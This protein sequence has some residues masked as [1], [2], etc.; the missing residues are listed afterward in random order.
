MKTKN[1]NR[2]EIEAI[3]SSPLYQ[4]L[5]NDITKARKILQLYISAGDNYYY[6]VRKQIGY[7]TKLRHLRDAY[8]SLYDEYEK[9][10]QRVRRRG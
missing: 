3:K 5:S 7:L 4:S 1:L 2:L 6:Y 8:L 10:I 9:N